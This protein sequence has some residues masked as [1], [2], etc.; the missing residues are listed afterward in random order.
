[1][2][3]TYSFIFLFLLFNHLDVVL[4]LLL[5]FLS[6]KLVFLGK[7]AFVMNDCWK[8][9]DEEK[10]KNG[11]VEIDELSQTGSHECHSKTET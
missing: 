10:T 9:V 6:K 3:T 2:I 11:S 7:T 1:M 8:E 5:F 4:R